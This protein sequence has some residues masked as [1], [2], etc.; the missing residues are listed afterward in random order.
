MATTSSHSTPSSDAQVVAGLRACLQYRPRVELGTADARFTVGDFQFEFY[1]SG[2]RSLGAIHYLQVLVVR[3]QEGA[4]RLYFSAETNP[5]E[6]PDAVYLSCFTPMRRETVL[7]SSAVALIDVF[8]PLASLLARRMLD[9][10]YQQCRPAA[11][12]DWHIARIP[13][14]LSEHCPNWRDDAELAKQLWQMAIEVMQA[15]L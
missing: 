12:E 11:E 1:R 13:A 14:A 3:T 7:R 15:P 8:V 4:E 10:P 9:L 2:L 6:G 5:M